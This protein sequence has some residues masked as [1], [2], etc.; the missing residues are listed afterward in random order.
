MLGFIGGG[1]MAEA[2]L[3]GIL[4]KYG[5]DII[6][7][8]LKDKRR[9]YLEET[10]HVKTTPDNKEVAKTCN[11]IIFAV[12]PQDMDNVIAEISDFI[13]E[14][15]TVVS[16]AAG[17]TLSYFSARL[18]T[19]KIVRVMPNTPALIQEGMSV[20]SMC[21]CIH[22]KDIDVIKDIFMSIG[23][24]LV[25][26]EK[27]MNAVTALSG[28][29]PA[30]FAYFIEAMIDGAVK[31]ELSRDDAVTLA[32]Q[33]LLGTARL[34]DTGMNPSRL[35]EMV[36]SP[37]GTTAAG[38]KLFEERGFKEIV[39]AAIEAATKRAKELGKS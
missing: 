19:R 31:M 22:D 10:Y 12:K 5:K 21:E 25:L 20:M 32:V 33:T 13:S 23:N 7:S 30:F 24:L 39:V 17:I 26:P 29:G 3:K 38:L 27:Y 14:D 34:L 15:K 35:R 9:A 2:I 36:T 37:G 11:I 8:E 28:S 4:G 1:N 18:K 16:I 6:V